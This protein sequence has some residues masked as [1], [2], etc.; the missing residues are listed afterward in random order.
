MT[1]TEL[2]PTPH[3]HYFGVTEL[4]GEDTEHPALRI[5]PDVELI[6]YR[7]ARRLRY[8]GSWTLLHV[9]AGHGVGSEHGMPLPWL[10]RFARLLSESDIDWNTLTGD[11][12][13]VGHPQH[14]AISETEWTVLDCW[15]R[16]VPV[17]P[18]ADSL[19]SS[20][21][22]IQLVCAN[23]RCEDDCFPGAPL[24]GGEDGGDDLAVSPHEVDA[25]FEIAEFSGW[26]CLGENRWLCET[27]RATHEPAPAYIAQWLTH[28]RSRRAA[29][30]RA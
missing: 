21:G 2:L 11:T 6:R 20:D 1:T 18:L 17:A 4:P 7:H 23:T 8:T 16:G 29:Y 12:R 9:P 3:Q 13:L 26:Q 24:T 27:C 28:V 22:L 25:L 5:A 19:R 14:A 15:L 10:R 30:E